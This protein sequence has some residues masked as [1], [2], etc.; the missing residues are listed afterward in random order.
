MERFSK[1]DAE[2]CAYTRRRQ[3]KIS[4]GR[5]GMRELVISSGKGGTGKTSV[6]A[7]LI[8]LLHAEQAVVIA[9]CDVD[10]ADLHLV[11]N[12]SPCEEHQF[13][14]GKE[15]KI[16]QELCT[17][18]G[19]CHALCRF[20]AIHANEHGR[21]EING[22][23]GCGVCVQFCP[24]KA[25]SFTDRHCGHW[26]IS[27]T[28]FGSFVHAK[29]LPGSE[30][31]GKL[32][33]LVRSQARALAIKNGAKALISDGCPGIACPVIASLSGADAVLAVAE[34]GL[35]S[36]HDVERLAQLVRHFKL[37]MALVINRQD[38]NLENT[39]RLQKLCQTTNLHYAGGIDYDELFTQAQIA[40]KSIIEHAPESKPAAQ[41]KEIY[42]SLQKA[43][44]LPAAHSTEES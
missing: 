11:L 43:G 15:A 25:I 39:A 7:A 21:L 18:C 30:N 17:N 34:P 12:P 33:S 14:S 44:F 36:L 16:Q 37:P 31:S 22:C 27:D 6:S 24:Q 32:V 1:K 9:D 42:T 8:S 23:E 26:Y 28:A 4:K 40:G 41:L 29:L 20:D 2:G 13:V 5:Y 3:E 35:S 19:A 38:I 10:A